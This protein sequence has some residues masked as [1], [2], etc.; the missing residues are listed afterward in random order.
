VVPL[1]LHT[2][3]VFEDVVIAPLPEPPEYVKVALSPTAREIGPPMIIV[4]W[5]TSELVIVKL[6]EP[7]LDK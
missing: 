5:L 6:V 2:D 7:V 3:G 1:T 4:A